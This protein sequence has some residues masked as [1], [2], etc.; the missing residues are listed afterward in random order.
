MIVQNGIEVYENPLEWTPPDGIGAPRFP[1]LCAPYGFKIVTV[2]G[3]NM[4]SPASEIDFRSLEA[5]RLGIRPEE[6]H[7]NTVCY[8]DGNGGCNTVTTCP[9]GSSCVLVVDPNTQQQHCV[10]PSP[11]TVRR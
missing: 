2:A 6:V 3:A 4:W 5:T 1:G 9:D 8:P 11:G 10:C 7:P